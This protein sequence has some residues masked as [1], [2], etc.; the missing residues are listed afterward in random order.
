M[1]RGLADIQPIRFPQGTFVSD[2][3]GGIVVSPDLTS[4]APKPKVSF[5]T[6]ENFL[7]GGGTLVGLYFL[8]KRGGK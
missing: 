4:P 7:I 2:G 1:I 8:S 6:A 5:F 3:S